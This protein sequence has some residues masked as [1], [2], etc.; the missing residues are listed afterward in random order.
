MNKVCLVTYSDENY[1]AQQEQLVQEAIKSDQFE[2]IFTYN[3]KDIDPDFMSM[4]KYILSFHRGGGYW[5]W[6]PYF[7]LRALAELKEGDILLY[8]DCGDAFTKGIE[9]SMLKLKVQNLM[10]D[11]DLYLTVGGFRHGDWTKRDCFHIMNCDT[12]E[13]YNR[14]QLEAGMGVFKKTRRT[15]EILNEWLM[16]CKISAVITDDPNI[17]GM[18]NLEGFKDHRHDQSILT[19]I[20]IRKNLPAGNFLREFINGNGRK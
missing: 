20:Y 7:I 15:I 8:M 16:F 1:A 6:K 17:C 19:N 13:Y 12:P 3:R 2:W 18:G 5:L 9:Y 10:K 11:L 4:N 14:I